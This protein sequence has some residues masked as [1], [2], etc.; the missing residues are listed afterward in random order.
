MVNS[1]RMI[2]QEMYVETLLAGA[3]Q[4]EKNPYDAI[5]KAAMYGE[6]A[7]I[8]E[9]L[10]ANPGTAETKAHRSL[11]LKAIEKAQNN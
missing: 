11:L 1:H 8:Q 5:S 10:K 9:M 6:I 2:L 3:L 4:A 7:R